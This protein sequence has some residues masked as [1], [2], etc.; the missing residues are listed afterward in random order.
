MGSVDVIAT[1]EASVAR[2]RTAQPAWAGLPVRARQRVLARFHDLVLQHSDAIVELIQEETSKA[3]RDALSEVL[4]VASTARMYSTRAARILR[5]E[6]R[7]GGLPL[8]TRARVDHEPY[9]VVGIIAP[10]NYPFLLAVGDALAA[11]VAGNAVVIKPSELT[12]RCT[13]LALDLLQQAGLPQDVAIAVHGTGEATGPGLIASV[14]YIC[15]TGSTRVGR[16]VAAAAAERLIPCSLELGGKNPAIVTRDADVADTAAGLIAGAFANGGQA[17][18]SIERVYVERPA[19]DALIAELV[20]R[21][22]ELQVAQD[23]D[24]SADVGSLVSESHADAV[25]AQVAA[26]VAAGARAVVGGVRRRELGPTVYE[27]TVLVDVPDTTPLAREE[28]FG[29]VMAVYVVDDLDAAVAAANDTEYGLNASVWAGSR[30]EAR[31]IAR[32]VHAGSVCTNATLLAYAAPD[33]EMGGWGISGIGRRHGAVGLLRFTRSRSRHESF[34]RGGG[35]DAILG[36]ATTPARA[37]LLVRAY[38]LWRR[39]PLVR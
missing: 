2:A 1:V 18:I 11:L 34:A 7:R 12:P 17:C 25:E 28:T 29:P 15:F 36:L 13:D 24:W 10:W 37:R 4:A 27:P 30:R 33:A 38:A 31:S 16:I 32:R 35:F 20:R 5:S 39:I 14:D 6:H 21:T 8:L 3:R 26:A 9:G 19:A 23:G 22:R